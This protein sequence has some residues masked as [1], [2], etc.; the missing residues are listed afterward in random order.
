M[1]QE[2]QWSWR[3]GQPSRFI[4]GGSGR[5][6]CLE[7]NLPCWGLFPYAFRQAQ[8]YPEFGFSSCQGRSQFYPGNGGG[9][10]SAIYP[11]KLPS[12]PWGTSPDS[13]TKA[14]DELGELEQIQVLERGKGLLPD[15]YLFGFYFQEWRKRTLVV[16][17]LRSVC[18]RRG[19]AGAWCANGGV[20]R[21]PELDQGP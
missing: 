9:I 13:R 8:C 21:R 16:R 6:T 17:G 11:P 19:D 10:D 20:A 1:V 7:G 2:W 3:F 4:R 5:G 15:Q 18:G 12:L 14:S